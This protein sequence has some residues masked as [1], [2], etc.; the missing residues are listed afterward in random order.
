MHQCRERCLICTPNSL[1]GAYL[2]DLA[3]SAIVRRGGRPPYETARCQVASSDTPTPRVNEFRPSP[4]LILAGSQSD[5]TAIHFMHSVIA[6][7]ES[8]WHRRSAHGRACPRSVGR[9]R[10][11]RQSTTP[12]Q[13]LIARELASVRSTDALSRESRRLVVHPSE[14]CREAD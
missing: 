5:T 3:T 13:F 9:N 6:T 2:C 8:K 12:P 10:S 11:A 14:M 1:G 7:E 4:K